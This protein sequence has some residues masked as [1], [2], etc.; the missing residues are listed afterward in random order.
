MHYGW[1]LATGVVLLL[2]GNALFRPGDETLARAVGLYPCL[3]LWA[4]GLTMMWWAKRHSIT[5]KF[6]VGLAMVLAPIVLGIATGADPK[7]TS[8]I[9]SI[10]SS[11]SI[12][13]GVFVMIST[14]L[15]M[16]YLYFTGQNVARVEPVAK[17]LPKT[18]ATS[19]PPQKSKVSRIPIRSVISKDKI[20]LIVGD[21]AEFLA[22]REW[23]ARLNA[24]I[25]KHK[26]VHLTLEWEG[27]LVGQDTPPAWF[28]SNRASVLGT[29]RSVLAHIFTSANCFAWRTVEESNPTI[30]PAILSLEP[31]YWFSGPDSPIENA[32]HVPTLDGFGN[33][34]YYFFPDFVLQIEKEVI[35]DGRAQHR[36]G[37]PDWWDELSTELQQSYIKMHP[38]TEYRFRIAREE[39][40]VWRILLHEYKA[41]EFL[42]KPETL[43]WNP[44]SHPF[45]GHSL[46]TLV[47]KAQVI[48]E[49]W[50]HRNMDGSKDHRNKD[51]P[52]VSTIEIG[53]VIVSLY[54]KRIG[55]LLFQTDSDAAEFARAFVRYREAFVKELDPGQ[56]ENANA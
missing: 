11:L 52:V 42:A 9:F 25:N 3:V 46:A 36:S 16:M 21:V 5:G 27:F 18:A 50:L 40:V 54:G 14:C 24:L 35:D 23:V 48:K 56:S 37:E 20:I 30:E 34:P 55:E 10:V 43:V 17:N 28:D 26:P 45:S 47:P 1:F 19:K 15:W 2:V 13:G 49:E 31:P 29:Q 33:K 12:V 6:L 44:H 4:I 41:F 53:V 39:K 51:N 38:K 7:R 8:G 22:P 32:V